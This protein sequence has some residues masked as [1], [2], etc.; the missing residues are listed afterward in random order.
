MAT[1]AQPLAVIAKLLDLTERRVQ[2]LSRAG[3]IPK[4]ER[5]RRICLA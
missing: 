1:N 5:V 3:V 2:Q 4:A